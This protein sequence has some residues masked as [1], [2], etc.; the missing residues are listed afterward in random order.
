VRHF[1]R[2]SGDLYILEAAYGIGIPRGN[3]IHPYAWTRGF[4]GSEKIDPGYPRGAVPLGEQEELVENGW[5]WSGP[6]ECGFWYYTQPL[7][8]DFADFLQPSIN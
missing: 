6:E 1:K 4:A 2:H 3:A 8:L 5:Q 7:F